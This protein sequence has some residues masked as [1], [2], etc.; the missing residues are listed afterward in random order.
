M[1]LL[2]LQIRKHLS[3]N[4]Q[5]HVLKQ[6]RIH[7]ASKVIVISQPAGRPLS[8]G[9]ALKMS[10]EDQ[11]A[12]QSHICLVFGSEKLS[13]RNSFPRTHLLEVRLLHLQIR[14]HLSVNG[15]QHVLKQRRIHSASKVIVISQPTGRPLW[16]G[17]ALK[18]SG[19]DKELNRV[20]LP[21][22]LDLRS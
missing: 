18:M 9:S 14:K 16:F 20:Y 1:R 4:G 21:S 2:H 10:G 13:C 11:R 7:S 19:E 5:Q 17:S 6:R 12:K 3:V 15:Q 22:L 8:F